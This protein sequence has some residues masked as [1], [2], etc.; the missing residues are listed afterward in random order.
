MPGSRT[1]STL[2]ANLLEVIGSILGLLGHLVAPILSVLYSTSIRG[3][4]NIRIPLVLGA[5][6]ELVGSLLGAKVDI[7]SLILALLSKK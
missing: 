5:I 4:C 3:V 7:F 2:C 6:L 1:G